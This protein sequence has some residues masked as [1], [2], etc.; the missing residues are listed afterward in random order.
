MKEA[1]SLVEARWTDSASRAIYDAVVAAVGRLPGEVVRGPRKGFTAF[2]RNFQF[3]AVR[4]VKGGAARL[5]LAVEPETHPRLVPARNEGWSERLHA[6]L[7]LSAPADVD[8]S[9]ET[10]LQAAW[11][12]R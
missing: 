2:S 3:A 1:D 12:R 5:G 4:P 7:P 10:L 11:E 6:A 9:V 8:K